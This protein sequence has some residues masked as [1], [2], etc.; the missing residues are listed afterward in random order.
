MET[1]KRVLGEEHPNTLAS[2]GNLA[3]TWKGLSRDKEALKLIEECVIM[4][5]MAIGTNHPDT[6]S[7]RI[8]LLGW[9]KE[10]LEISALIDRE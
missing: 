5:T 7:S 3:F 10:E 8:V 1:W 2:M 9:Q 6:L 4:Q